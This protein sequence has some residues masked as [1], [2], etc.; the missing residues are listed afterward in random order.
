MGLGLGD[1][2]LQEVAEHCMCDR[3][4]E[5]IREYLEQNIKGKKA[6]EENQAVK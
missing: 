3:V 6:L 2:E 5:H 4:I 1:A